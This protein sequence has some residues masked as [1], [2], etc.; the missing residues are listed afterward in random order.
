MAKLNLILITCILV[1]VSSYAQTEQIGTPKLGFDGQKLTIQYDFINASPS[2]QYYVWVMIQNKNGET[3]KMNSITGDIGETKAGKEKV[4]NW[5]PANDSVFLNEEVTVEIQAEKYVKSFNKGSVMLRSILLPGLGQTRVSGGKPYWIMGIV[6]YG[7]LAGGFV[8]YSGYKDSYDKYLAE[9]EDMQK[10]AD[11]L[12][13]AEQKATM[14][15][16]MFVT[17]A[18]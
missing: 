12:S 8:T 4:I 15:G 6:S 18:A 10:R 14:A 1:S 13:E 2:D 11:Y 17:A 3:L 7:A 5:I 9:T 16:A